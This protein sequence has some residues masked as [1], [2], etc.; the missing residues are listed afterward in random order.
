MALPNH[1][2]GICGHCIPMYIAPHRQTFIYIIEN[3]IKMNLFT[4]DKTNQK[5]QN[6]KNT[7]SRGYGGEK[8]SDDYFI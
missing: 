7:K 2:S 3:K 6:H 5:R 8:E 4:K 1:E